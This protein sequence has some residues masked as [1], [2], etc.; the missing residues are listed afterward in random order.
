MQKGTPKAT[1]LLWLLRLIAVV[2][3]LVA[4]AQAV[5]AGGLLE[6]SAGALNLHQITGTSIITSISLL[7][8]IVA[9][10]CW[11]R[12]QHAA[13]FAA[14]SAGLFLAEAVQIGLGFNDQLTL[15]VPL[16]TAIFGVALVLAFASLRHFEVKGAPGPA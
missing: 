10:I 12:G 15:H 14:A 4:L 3:A 7:Q 2:H 13:W 9:V 5:F 8:V 6:G 16:G 11:K 1:N